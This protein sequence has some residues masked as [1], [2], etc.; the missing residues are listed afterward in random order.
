M[1]KDESLKTQGAPSLDEL[2]SVGQLPSEAEME[3]RG[4]LCIECV[5]EIPCN[6]CQTS[7]PQGAITVGFPITNLPVIDRR[8]CTVCGLCIP[9]CPG[10]AIT[11][12]SIS[13]DI[14]RIRFPWEYLPYPEIGAAVTMVNRLGDGICEGKI[15]SIANP[16]RNKRTAVVTAEFPRAFARDVIS[17]ARSNSNV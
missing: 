15:V 12:K 2:R 5:E 13:G 14:A 11:I 16:E 8:K 7:C 4:C 3:G 9:A 17:I 6:P 10:L 1:S